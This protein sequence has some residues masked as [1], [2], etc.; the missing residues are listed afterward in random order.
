MGVLP[1][2]LNKKF[3]SALQ[4]INN[5]P[6]LKDLKNKL[7]KNSKYQSLME[8]IEELDINELDFFLQK[9]KLYQ[10]ILLFF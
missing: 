3:E 4:H 2:D 8:L 5:N 7:Q 10:Q 6:Q 1:D 9:I